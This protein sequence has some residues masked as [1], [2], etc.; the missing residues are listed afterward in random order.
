MGKKW[1]V[2]ATLKLTTCDLY[3]SPC[4]S[5]W[6]PITWHGADDYVTFSISPCSVTHPWFIL[7]SVRWKVISYD[8]ILIHPLL[9]FSSCHCYYFHYYFCTSYFL[10]G[11]W[12]R[13]HKLVGFVSG[14]KGVYI[15]KFWFIKTKVE[16]R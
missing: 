4:F 6:L 16:E 13:Q 3:P 2:L 9:Y 8:H 1:K 14:I 5:G 15:F 7:F 10:L 11:P 12:K